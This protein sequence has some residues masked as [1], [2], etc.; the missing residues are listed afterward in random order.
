[1][2]PIGDRAEDRSY[3]RAVRLNR[4]GLAGHS[5]PVDH[6]ATLLAKDEGRESDAKGYVVNQLNDDRLSSLRVT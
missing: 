1:M 5:G 6:F 2:K 4:S 3:R